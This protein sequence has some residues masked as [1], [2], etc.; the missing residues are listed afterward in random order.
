[1]SDP[2]AAARFIDS[3]Q[4]WL[5]AEPAADCLVDL[6]AVRDFLAHLG[7]LPADRAMRGVCAEAISPRLI[8]VAERLKPRL[9]AAP[10]PLV[11]EMHSG[12][13]ELVRTLLDISE[14]LAQCES[15]SGQTPKHS[16]QPG[17]TDENRRFAITAMQMRLVSEAFLLSCMGGVEAARSVWAA[18]TSIIDKH[19]DDVD[20]ATIPKESVEVLTGLKRMLAM[21]VLQPESLTTRE[22]VWVFDYLELLAGRADLSWHP[23]QP[24]ESVFWLDIVSAQGPVAQIRRPPMPGSKVLYFSAMP[25]A[26][27]IGEQIDWLELRITEAEVLGMER[28]GDLLDPDSSGLPLGLQPVEVLSLMRRM[29]DRWSEPL[30]RGMPRRKTLYDVQVC[31]G[32]RDIWRMFKRG[33]P[34]SDVSTWRVVNESPGGYALLSVGEFNSP[35]GPGDA[36]ML[37]RGVGEPWILC[38]VRWLRHE[39]AEAVEIGLKVV[40]QDAFPIT[41]AFRGAVDRAT[42][43]ALGLPAGEHRARPAVMTPA[44]TYT[45][46][47]FIMVREMAQLYV[48][49]GRVINLEM[50]TAN[51]ELFQYEIDPYPI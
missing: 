50:Q 25:L 39:S 5:N 2:S 10:L 4:V 31:A 8:D 45:S 37:R 40:A 21:S 47:R 1:M 48:A 38:V 29:R 49:Q 14:L 43:P 3:L 13:V 44:G 41:I 36:L 34:D 20:A 7:Q 16:V 32:L 9:L 30:N 18:A 12:V 24:E 33:R 28:D 17:T 26:K 22:Q 15:A 51:I 23:M 19:A 42:T 6:R 27:R 46:R 35:I 11:R